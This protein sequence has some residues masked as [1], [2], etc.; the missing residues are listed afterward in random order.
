[1]TPRRDERPN[2]LFIALDDLNEWIGCLGVN[3]DVKT[4]HMDRL[5]EEGMAFTNACCPS[6]VCQPSRTA[7]L[8]GLRPST[9]G[10][11]LLNDRPQDS[12]VWDGALPLPLHFRHNG[13]RAMCVGKVDHGN[14]VDKATRAS[15][16]ESLWDEHGGFFGGQQFDMR[17]RHTSC[18]THVDGYY[19]WAFHWGPLDDDQAETL[20]DRH[21]ARWAAER[22]G[23][24]YD[25]P[26]FL[27]AGFFRPHVPL[28]A[29][30]RFFEMY[31][32]SEL[33]LPPT[34]PEDLD[35]MPPIARQIALAG[36]QDFKLGMH[37][38][39]TEHGYWRDLVQAY[40]ACVSFVDDCVGQVLEALDESPYADNTIVVLWGDN[41]WSLGEH[42]H[43]KKWSIWDCGA[44]VPL[45]IRAPGVTDGGTPC[46]EG[47]DLTDL[48]PTLV[49]LCGLP[50]VAGLDGQ[51]LRELLSGEQTERERPGLTSFGPNNHSLRTRR[52]RYSRYCD[53][54]EEL[55]DHDSD[56]YEHANVAGRAEFEPVRDSLARWLPEEN[57]PALASS[58]SQRRLHLEPGQD[59]WFRGAQ[60]GFA[61]SRITIRA[62]VKAEAEEGVIVHHGAWFAGY[63]LYIEKGRL[64]MAVMDVPGSLRWDNLETRTTVVRADEPL[65]EGLVQVEGCLE[66][67]GTITLKV[68]DAIV[69]TGRADGPLSIYP[70][71]LLEAGCYTRTH[72]PAIG[73]YAPQEEFPGV[74]RDI[75]VEFGQ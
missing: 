50:E 4:P 30:R 75:R 26:F 32:K 22:L 64:H 63:A 53:G 6:P 74:L 69:G 13:Y 12:P 41:G 15:R 9:T 44:R 52:W 8:S 65:P 28:I 3:P 16:G 43:W 72:Y 7:L 57:A 38:Q 25:S 71:G 56:P 47:V 51:S 54:T 49:D 36:Y 18:L 55:Y 39:I 11:Y 10:C 61:E 58:P 31:D 14:L 45:I 37:R 40:L 27:A 48:Y 29:P 19:K 60:S 66:T 34:G 70:A 42:F 5:A 21:V 1:M 67:D 59:V 33:H 62:K 2:V 24:D 17:S 46:E 73:G 68:D 23:R 35:D 20:T